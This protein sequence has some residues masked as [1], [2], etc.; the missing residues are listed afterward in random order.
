MPKSPTPQQKLTAAMIAALPVGEEVADPEHKGLRVRAT[1]TGRKVFFYRY[2]AEDKA[3]REIKLGELGPLT[4]AKAREALAKLKLERAQG[5][6]PQE[7]KRASREAARA[8]REAKRA[9]SYTVA[10]LVEDEARERLA[11]LKRGD[12]MERLLRREL[13]A[14]VGAVPAV[15]LTR[16]DL[17]EKVLRPLSARAPRLAT[18]L[19]S[20]VRMAYRHAIKQGRIADDFTLPTEGL[21]GAAQVRRKRAFSDKELATFLR[22]LPSSSYSRTVRDAL[23]LVLLTG[24]R[25]GEVVA[26]RWRDIDLER[27][28]WTILDTKNGEPV[29]V[30]LPA[31]AVELLRYRR[32]VD[33]TFLFPS[34]VAGQHIAQKAIGLAQYTARNGRGEVPADDPI[35]VDWTVHDLRRTVATGL[36]RLGCPR[37]VQDRILN[38]VD[39]SVSAIYDRHHYD[40]EAREWLQRWAD[41][42]D[43]LSVAKV[44]PLDGSR[45]A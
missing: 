11:K 10:A 33:K 24:C 29:D 5:I 19:L 17:R 34:R 23:R 43:G 40:A 21:Q 9:L 22:W 36:A 3:L 15:D 4:L 8:D 7:R 37:V 42:L 41:H 30:M 18:M 38:H 32:A 45:A 28:V 14:K 27:G 44:I 6:D 39:A 1:A 20:A 2:R 35:E 16:Q 13:V 26:A 31:Q 25:S 12:E